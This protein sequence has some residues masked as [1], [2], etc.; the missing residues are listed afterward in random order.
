M[1]D[2]REASLRTLPG[3]CNPSA[4]LKED[5][6]GIWTFFF[7]AIDDLAAPYLDVFP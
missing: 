1:T 3:L 6:E 7:K 4:W 5:R 2:K